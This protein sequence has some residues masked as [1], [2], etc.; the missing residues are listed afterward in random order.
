MKHKPFEA[1]L[2]SSERLDHR[3]Q[4]EL[5]SHLLD[6]PDCRAVRE[7]LWQAE[8]TLRAAPMAAP[9]PGFASRWSALQAQEVVRRKR[10]AGWRLL[11]GVMSAITVTILLIGFVFFLTGGSLTI[12]FAGGLQESVR[13]VLWARTFGEIGQTITRSLPLA[14]VSGV[15]LSLSALATATGLTAV[16]WSF[17]IRRFSVR[18]VSK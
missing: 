18:G 15:F 12:L 4:Q 9:T 3:Q 14:T 5:A 11:A 6:C 2:L 16:A 13:W 17:S 1:W 8:S 10:A 7:A